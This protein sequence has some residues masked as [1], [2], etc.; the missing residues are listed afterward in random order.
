MISISHFNLFLMNHITQRLM[1]PLHVH[2]F[3]W[4][5]QDAGPL[6]EEELNARITR[7]IQHAARKQQ[8]QQ[9][10]K[11][12]RQAQEIQRKLQVMWK[13]SAGFWKHL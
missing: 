13:T 1:E 6:T 7:K 8:K 12:L 3:L 5:C 10:Q 11:R 9:E 2:V 4:V